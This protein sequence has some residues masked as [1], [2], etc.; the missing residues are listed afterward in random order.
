MCAEV[1]AI[2]SL[3]AK[4]RFEIQQIRSLNDSVIYFC[5]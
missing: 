5:C 2:L 4:G 1:T 3:P